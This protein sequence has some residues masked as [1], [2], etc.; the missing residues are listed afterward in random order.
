M[1]EMKIVD[2]QCC[3][4]CSFECRLCCFTRLRA[5]RRRWCKR[6]TRWRS[7]WRLCSKKRDDEEW[8]E[9]RLALTTRMDPGYEKLFF[10]LL[11]LW[12]MRCQN[13]VILQYTLW[14]SE[15]LLPN[16]RNATYQS[17]TVPPPLLSN[18][19]VAGGCKQRDK[20]ELMS[21]FDDSPGSLAPLAPLA[22]LQLHETTIQGK[23]VNNF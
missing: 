16:T 21:L 11:S 23:E 4:F 17:V 12:F 20:W 14:V 6:S 19:L 9:P 7:M 18:L 1:T 15:N 8:H 5:R 10:S 3:K 13:S 22:N 2:E